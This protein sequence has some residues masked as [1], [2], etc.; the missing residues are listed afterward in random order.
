MSRGLIEDLG[1]LYTYGERLV[2]KDAREKG[3]YTVAFFAHFLDIHVAPGQALDD[4]VIRSDA[5]YHWRMKYASGKKPSP[6]L[7]DEFLEF[8]LR[9]RPDL[10]GLAAALEEKMGHAPDINVPFSPADDEILDV[11]TDHTDEELEELLRRMQQIAEE[12]NEVHNGGAK[13]I[14]TRGTS[15]YGHLGRSAGGIRVGGRS[16]HLSARMVLNDPRYFPLEMNS[17]LSDNNM[18]AALAALK[19]VA[20]HST[21]LELDIEETIRLGAKRRGLFLPQLRS[22]DEDRLNVLLLIDNGGFSMDP[23]IPAVRTLF[24]KMKTRFGHDLRIYYF[25][26]IIDS[27]VHSDQARTR[28][29]V[30][31]ESLLREGE[32]HRVFIV[33]DASMAPYE[34]HGAWM[35]KSGFDYLREMAAAFPRLAWMNPVSE[36]AW[37]RTETIDD[38]RTIIKMFPL[39]PRGIEKAVTHMNRISAR[40]MEVQRPIVNK[41]Y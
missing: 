9:R 10:R 32:H 13:F 35:G 18:D 17:I 41:V 5:F 2:V 38:I 21:H 12:Q 34:L 40:K 15:P 31:M 28:E 30:M 1:G 36:G 22:E 14:G 33:G 16:A 4:A 8:V 37:G 3:P 29:P 24:Q 39:T 23:Y 6:E 20:E 7:I 19:G 25:H 11:D 26:N 27:T